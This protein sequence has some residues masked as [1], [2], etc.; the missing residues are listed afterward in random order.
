MEICFV[1]GNKNKLRE[2]KEIISSELISKDIDLPE[3]Q[4]L[5]AEKV[6]EH[7]VKEAYNILKK[8]V[9]VED[10]GFYIKSWND[11]PGAFIKWALKSMKSNGIYNAIK[12]QNDKSVVAEAC[13]GYYDGNEVKIFK[14]QLEGTLTSPKGDNGFGFDNI[15]IPNGHDK[16]LAEMT[17]E[18]KNKMSMRKLALEKF[19]N[20]LKNN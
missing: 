4:E 13:I 1:T 15:F 5:Y 17:S 16:T 11:F 2:A 6:I 8:P 18:E 9:M 19:E 10:V 20:F 12:D 7:K 3:V 14:G